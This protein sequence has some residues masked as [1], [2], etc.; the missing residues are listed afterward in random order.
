M[1]PDTPLE[2]MPPDHSVR[3]HARFSPSKL[4]YLD[5][6]IGGCP[7]FDNRQSETTQAA[8]E[9]TAQHEILDRL[10]QQA[11]AE[12]YFG[13]KE[14]SFEGYLFM[15]RIREKVKWDDDTDYRLRFCARS[16]E[17]Y[18]KGATFKNT[19]CEQ[20]VNVYDAE[21][22]VMMYGHFD[23]L[24]ERGT[25]AVL[26]DWKFG[27]NPVP[28]AEINRQGL[29]Y[30][31]GVFQ[32][33]HHLNQVAVMFV[34][35][36]LNLVS[37]AVY[38]RSQLPEMIRTIKRIFDLATAT[39]DPKADP[40]IA[41]AFLNPG[42][43]C[44]YCGRFTS[45]PAYLAKMQ[46]AVVLVGG[47]AVPDNLHLEAIDTPEK[48]ALAAAWCDFLT[49]KLP[50]IKSRC[51]EVVKAA[52][53]E[54]KFVA[55]DGTTY[56]YTIAQRN[57]DRGLGGALEVAEA[58]KDWATEAQVLGAASLSLGKLTD[59]VVPAIQESAAGQG[60]ELTKKAATERLENHLSSLG[61]LTRPDGHI[62]VLKKKSVQ[63][64]K[65]PKVKALT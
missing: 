45:C 29:A 46:K 41:E 35:P 28:D 53:G 60:E 54:A 20:R 14:V 22:K 57:L 10:L 34:Q 32:K 33:W 13:G 30:A 8:E 39:Q 18:L 51:K 11:L 58:L 1:T 40:A 6:E 12:D 38:K 64:T 52:G 50:D 17:K 36:K 59:I 48:A 55:P 43:A 24:M 62:E 19:H 5:V 47:L 42:D 63:K 21:G 26:A 15:A 4:N 44:A 31:L 9:G 2:V 65:K 7:G 61:L 37:T 23:V 49:D 27:V 16:V 25:S 56:E 3:S